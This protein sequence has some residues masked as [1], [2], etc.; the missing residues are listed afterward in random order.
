MYDECATLVVLAICCVSIGEFWNRF[1]ER[2]LLQT[3]EILASGI[4]RENVATTYSRVFDHASICCH[5]KL[6][7]ACCRGYQRILP[8]LFLQSIPEVLTLPYNNFLAE[9]Q[10]FLV[11][12]D[13]HSTCS[14]TLL[15]HAF[16]IDVSPGSP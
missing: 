4:K 13:I 14:L 7:H 3:C 16:S 5:L 8:D 10:E 6:L 15:K 11:T 9:A 1:F 12:L 2:W